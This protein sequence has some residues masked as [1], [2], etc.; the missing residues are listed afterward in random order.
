MVNTSTPVANANSATVRA[1][2]ST[3]PML[4]Q[5]QTTPKILSDMLHSMHNQMN[6]PEVE[7][8]SPKELLKPL[9]DE[10]SKEIAGPE[11]YEGFSTDINKLRARGKE[12]L[13]EMNSNPVRYHAIYWNNFKDL[14][15]K[16]VYD[17]DNA[18]VQP[19]A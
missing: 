3:A 14:L 2:E 10:L 13:G 4:R 6:S 7:R 11:P 16:V 18:G 12:L 1:T 5:G 19:E 8:K 15:R 17:I 9:V